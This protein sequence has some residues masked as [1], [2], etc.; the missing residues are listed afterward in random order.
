MTARVSLLHHLGMLL[1][2]GRNWYVDVDASNE[3][4]E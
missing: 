2:Q 4:S 3:V 1:G